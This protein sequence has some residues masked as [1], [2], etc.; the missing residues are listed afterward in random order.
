MKKT[1]QTNTTDGLLDAEEY[2]KEELEALD[3]Y[4]KYSGK[5]FDDDEIYQLMVRFENNE[6]KIKEE[7]DEMKKIASKGEEYQWNEV[8]KSKLIYLILFNFFRKK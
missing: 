5:I 3:Y 7:L 2:T 8:G 4:Q 1:T 6:T